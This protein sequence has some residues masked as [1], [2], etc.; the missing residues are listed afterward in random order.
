M[1]VQLEVQAR[2]KA[3]VE[4][5]AER[6]EAD[7][8][9]LAAIVYG[10][11]ARGEAWERS[12]IDMLIITRDGQERSSHGDVWLLE[13]EINVSANLVTRSEL[14]RMLDGVLQGSMMHSVRSQ[15]RLIFCKDDSIA[16]WL[17]ENNLIGARDQEYVALRNFASLPWM[18][19]KIQKWYSI[20]HDMNYCVIWI[21]MAVNAL[22]SI[23]V[24]LHGEAPG[25][26][27]LDQALKLNPEFFRAVYIDLVNGPKTPETIGAVIVRLNA[28]IDERVPQL[29]KPIFD[30]LAQAQGPV[31]AAEMNQFFSKKTQGTYLNLVYDFLARKGKIHRLSSPVRLTRKSQVTL[32]EPAFYYDTDDIS[33]WE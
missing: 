16:R 19:D 18:L 25:R 31:T 26:E 2:Y 4:S 8:Y 14:K 27:A 13:D 9:I 7:Y 10:S 29:C 22:A 33:D 32:D 17:D 1:D 30:Y 20:K 3:A 21:L 23:E 28:Y 15:S 12:D 24:I 5:L 11:V 6:L